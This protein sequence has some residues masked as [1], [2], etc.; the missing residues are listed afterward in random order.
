MSPTPATSGPKARV[1]IVDDDPRFL[2]AIARL[3]KAEHQIA[4]EPD[5]V[6]VVSRL[7]AEGPFDLILCDLTMPDVSGP[8]LREQVADKAPHYLQRMVFFTGGAVTQEATQ[9]L[10]RADVVH[11]SKYLSPSSLRE[12]VAAQV[13][14]VGPYSAPVS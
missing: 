6:R 10:T 9:F 5:A 1:L 11:I 4:T 8:Q 14:R 7:H 2:A 12:E 13:K 3:L